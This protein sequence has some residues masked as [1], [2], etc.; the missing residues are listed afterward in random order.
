M[1]RKLASI[2]KIVDIQSIKDADRIEVATI[3]GWQVVVAKSD[4]FKINDLIVYI[5]TDSIVP[6]RPEFEF[7]RERKFRVRIIKLKKTISQGL[8]LPLTMLK[9]YGE[10]KYDKFNNIIGLE[11]DG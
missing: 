10:L 3:L 9:E 2:Q 5:E 1:E 11:I 7:L 6:E 8:V 4:N